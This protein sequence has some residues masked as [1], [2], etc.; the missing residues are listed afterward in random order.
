MGFTG[1]M[2]VKLGTISPSWYAVDN[3]M[4]FSA[5]YLPGT[6]NTTVDISV[7]IPEGTSASGPADRF[8][9]L[10]PSIN[11]GPDTS[12]GE[13]PA[14]LLPVTTNDV[15]VGRNF[16]VGR[17]TVTGT[18]IIGKIVTDIT[19]S[20]P[21]TGI[22]PVPGLAYQYF[23]L[24]PARY[25][26]IISTTIT[27]AVP[28]SWLEEHHLN[29]QDTVIYHYTGGARTALPMTV[30]VNANGI[31]SFTATSPSISRF[32]IAGPPGA[33]PT[34]IATISA[35]P[36]PRHDSTIYAASGNCNAG[37]G[38]QANPR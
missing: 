21:A 24:V 23:E 11:T 8:T 16:A 4:Q 36:S 38:R 12:D 1:S 31:I 15:N 20:S 27:F 22:P 13:G 18:G 17:T 29:P 34:T 33:V 2:D 25:T 14:N 28:V 32:A 37:A 10:S 19:Q 35:Q 26:Y 9:Y 7:I 5:Y 30:G 3:D 6:A